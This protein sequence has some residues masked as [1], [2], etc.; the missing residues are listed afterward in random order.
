MNVAL[1]AGVP[2]FT[3]EYHLSKGM[4]FLLHYMLQVLLAEI[5]LDPV[6]DVLRE[7]YLNHIAGLL[8]PEWVGSGLDSNRA[9]TVKYT[10][11]GDTALSRHFDNAEVTLNVCLGRQFT[12]GDLLVGGMWKVRKLYLLL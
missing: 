3:H 5:S 12:G 9:F 6:F 1:Q 8:Y 10:L 7:N 2:S 4:V 11:G